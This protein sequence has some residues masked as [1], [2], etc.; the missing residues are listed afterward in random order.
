MRIVLV[1]I[2]LYLLLYSSPPGVEMGNPRNIWARVSTPVCQVERENIRGRDGIE[3]E[4]S[5]R[6]RKGEEE[7]FSKTVSSPM[8]FRKATAGRTG[9]GLKTDLPIGII[10]VVTFLEKRRVSRDSLSKIIIGTIF[11]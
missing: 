8:R 7:S 9:Q 4:M 5:K 2:P 1:S 10:K 11:F 3:T 6:T